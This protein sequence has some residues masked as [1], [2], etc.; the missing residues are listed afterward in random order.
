MRVSGSQNGPFVPL[1]SI[2]YALKVHLRGRGRNA[3]VSNA[4]NLSHHFYGLVLAAEVP[5]EFVSVTFT[6]PTVDASPLVLNICVYV[7]VDPYASEVASLYHVEKIVIA[8]IVNVGVASVSPVA[9]VKSNTAEDTSLVFENPCT[10]T[11]SVL[12]DAEIVVPE[13]TGTTGGT[14]ITSGANPPGVTSVP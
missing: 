11:V 2:T 14:T 10:T 8:G 3:S 5:T 1:I 6:D 7:N 12:P 9:A 4:L 13:I